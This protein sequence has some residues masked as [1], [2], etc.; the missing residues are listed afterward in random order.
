MRLI[1]INEIRL[2]IQSYHGKTTFN[3]E[4]SKGMML[5]HI[6]FF[7]S[8]NIIYLMLYQLQEAT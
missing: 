4:G 3:R 7:I 2:F 6:N 8:Y 5:Y 1:C